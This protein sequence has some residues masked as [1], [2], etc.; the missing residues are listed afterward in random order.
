VLVSV[1]AEADI[2]DG[3]AF[4]EAKGQE[5]GNYFYLSIMADLH[6]LAVFGGIHSK[7]FGYHCMP[8]KRFPFAIYYSIADDTVHVVAILDERRDPDWVNQRLCRR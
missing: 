5:V 8:A 1:E 3:I 6:A 7:R 4:Y 2:I